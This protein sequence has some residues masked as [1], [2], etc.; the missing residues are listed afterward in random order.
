MSRQFSRPSQGSLPLSQA[1]PRHGRHGCGRHHHHGH[2]RVRGGPGQPLRR[3]LPRPAAFLCRPNRVRNLLPLIL[4]IHPSLLLSHITRE[5]ERE[6]ELM[7]HWREL[8]CCCR[9]NRVRN[10]HSPIFC[11]HP[12]LLLSHITRE[13]EREK[14]CCVGVNY[15]VAASSCIE[16]V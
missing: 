14:L 16:L 11:I 5:R 7:L 10:L 8:W 1:L 3:S 13:T 6:R 12:S 2:T 9:P 15:G 4:C